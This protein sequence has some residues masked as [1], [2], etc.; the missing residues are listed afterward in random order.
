MP[1]PHVSQLRALA[2]THLPNANTA[3]PA[4]MNSQLQ[5]LSSTPAAVVDALTR[6]TIEPIGLLHLERLVMT[7]IDIERGELV[8]SLPLAPK[9]R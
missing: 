7:P 8:Y 1:D 4:A 6:R 9:R 5:Q 3:D 2:A